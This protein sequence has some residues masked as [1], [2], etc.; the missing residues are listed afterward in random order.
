MGKNIVVLC[1]GTGNQ[2]EGDL[3]NV[4]K[5]FRIAVKNEQQVVYYNPGVGTIGLS[6]EWGR[7]FQ[8]A[9]AIFG[10]ATGYGLDDNIADAYRFVCE[11]YQDGDRLFFFGF[12][13][14]SYTVRALAGM[15]HLIGLLQPQQLNLVSYALTAFKRTKRQKT[16]HR[17]AWEFG[18][19]MG[20]R[21]ASIHFLGVWD[22]VA[23]I[24]V[25]RPDRFYLPSLRTLPFTRN[26]PSVRCFRHAIA[27]D[28]RRRLFRL[29]KWEP[30]Q[31][32]EPV[33]FADPPSALKQDAVEMGFAGV[34]SDVGG[35][36]PE[37]ESGLSKFPL[38]WLIEEAVAQDLLKDADMYEHLV[39]GKLLPGGRAFYVGP[40]ATAELHN[41]LTWGWWILELL[42]KCVRW[43]EW[44]RCSIFGW[45]LP[46]A[47]PRRLPKDLVI[48][49][50]V[51]ERHALV[52]DYRP[53]NVAFS[54]QG[55]ARP[56]A[57]KS[58]AGCQWN[59]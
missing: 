4:L 16:K 19:V 44:R 58:S 51:D 38:A 37:Q 48:H 32:Y 41:S 24:I 17:L 47:E 25:P 55:R 21:H 15:I 54:A 22:T 31:I 29:N 11:H 52:G 14:G 43:R 49:S 35:G 28:E 8:D 10:L 46:L 7:V 13:R 3:S 18:R 26:N 45:Y 27:I 56:V 6:S 1:D 57:P 23:S 2:V 33:P 50:S 9:K 53:I 39:N 40:L 20:A 30:D 42:P 36:Y 59:R 34:H 5:L 12:S